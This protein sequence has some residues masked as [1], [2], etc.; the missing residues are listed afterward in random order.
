[1]KKPAANK[2]PANASKLRK[3]AVDAKAG[4]ESAPAAAELLGSASETLAPET[5]APEMPAPET[6]APE[7][8]APEAPA[9]EAPAPE[10]PAPEAPAPEAPAPEAPA[11]EAPATSQSAANPSASG[12]APRAIPSR[13]PA[14]QQAQALQKACTARATAL[15]DAAQKGDFDA[16]T[17]DFDAPMRAALPPE[18]FKAAWE[19]LARFGSLQAR[20]Q[21]HAS[22][23]QGY[24]A[25]TI[26]LIFDKVNLYAQ[27]A[28]GSDGRIAGFYV[29][30][31]ETPAQ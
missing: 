13:S 11:P 31:L 9:P 28:C 25:I 8:P 1:M 29:K 10:A 23:L 16:A 12:S 21:S 5:P 24:L 7:A 30:P 20:G 2:Q 6:P 3:S 18:K 26:P 14:E 4:K 22:E 15:L 27:I 19:S 17:H